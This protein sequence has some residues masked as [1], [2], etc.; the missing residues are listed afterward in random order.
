M[1]KSKVF[2]SYARP[3]QPIVTD[4]YRFLDQHGCDPWMDT[5]KLLPG[6]DWEYEVEVAIEGSSAFVACLSKNSVNRIG[7]AQTELKTALKYFDRFPEG[8]I[9]LIPVRLDDCEVPRS[10][11]A[12]NWLDWFDYTS[13]PKLIEVLI[14]QTV[15]VVPPPSSLSELSRLS[16]A[17]L[18]S[19]LKLYQVSISSSAPNS[20]DLLAAALTYIVLESFDTSRVLLEKIRLLDPTLSYAWY[21]SAIA[22]LRGRR[23]WLLNRDEALQVQAYALRALQLN[24]SQSHFAF[25]LALIKEDFFQNKGFRVDDPDLVSCIQTALGTKPNREELLILL[26]SVQIPNSKITQL[27]YSLVNA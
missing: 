22:E 8:K 18:Q 24:A 9:F 25:L 21:A 19:N 23:P 16:L 6:Q 3:D 1:T 10:L 15:Q 14:S 7:Y 11:R 5:E 26:K 4:I 12:Q 13:R 27:I 2:L 17:E 20:A